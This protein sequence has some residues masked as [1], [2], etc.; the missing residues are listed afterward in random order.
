MALVLK[1]HA[2]LQHG[3]WKT[4]N[5]K[6]NAGK[7]IN[8]YSTKADGH[9]S[10]KCMERGSTPL[11]IKGQSG[12]HT[13]TVIFINVYKVKT[14]KVTSIDESVQKSEVL[15]IADGSVK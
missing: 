15:C 4:T 14:Q 9:V 1:I 2:E 13:F 10:R 12:L 8:Q 5:P 6:L 7:D 11:A 3:K